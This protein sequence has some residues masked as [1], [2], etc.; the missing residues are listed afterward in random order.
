MEKV[1]IIRICVNWKVDMQRLYCF[2]LAG[3]LEKGKG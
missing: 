2:G 3:I 1:I